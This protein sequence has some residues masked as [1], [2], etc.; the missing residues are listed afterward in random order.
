MPLDTKDIEM[1][2]HYYVTTEKCDERFCEQ[3]K[4]IHALSNNITK[5]ATKLNIIVGILAGIGSSILAVAI[6]LLFE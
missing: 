1:L 4:Q 3:N 6:K 5:I 2:N